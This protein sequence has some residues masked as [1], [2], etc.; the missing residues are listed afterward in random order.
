MK[1]FKC[2]CG[3]RE[4]NIDQGNPGRVT[5]VKCVQSYTWDG[6]AFVAT[7]KI[8]RILQ[9][10]EALF[11]TERTPIV[12]EPEV[13]GQTAEEKKFK[14]MLL[15]ERKG[16]KKRKHLTRVIEL[17]KPLTKLKKIQS[18]SIEE[19]IRHRWRQEIIMLLNY[20]T[21]EFGKHDHKG[22]LRGVHIARTFHQDLKRIGLKTKLIL[23]DQRGMVKR[24]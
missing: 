7:T 9:E 3:G 6:K 1:K 13:F 17:D 2:K 8:K 11:R 20:G 23:K 14:A 18:M 12:V 19:R 24:V 10:V 15:A 21:V 5:C 22:K 4:F 16:V